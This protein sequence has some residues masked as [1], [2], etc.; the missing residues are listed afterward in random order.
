LIV[1]IQRK[2]HVQRMTYEDFEER[3]RDGEV[4]PE[5]LIRFE[6]VT[7]DEFRPVGELELYHALAD[8]QRLA[9]RASLSRSGMPIVTAML[10]GFQLR[11]YLLSWLGGREEWLERTFTNWSPAIIEQGQV[12]RLISY[13]LLQTSFTHLL[14]NLYFLA[15]TAYHLE[16]AM[17]RANLLL[18]Y[19]GSVFTGGL[20]S[21]VMA[22]DRPSLGASCGVF[23][24]LAAVV[25]LG[26]KH[27][28]NL[29]RQ[30][31]KYFGWALAPYLGFSILSGLSA[32]NVDNWGHLGGLV[33]GVVLMTVLDPELIPEQRAANART[34]QITLALLLAITLGL[35]TAGTRLVPLSRYS[36]EHGW[37]VR[38]P[39]PWQEG[40]TFTGDR[41]WF[42]PTLLA[43]VSIATTVHPRP[44]TAETA[45]ENLEKRIASGGKNPKRVAWE[46][47]TIQ[48]WD[49]IRMVLRFD[50]SGEP[51]EVT[52][53][54]LVRGVYEHRILFQAL[55]SAARNYDPLIERI[56][57]SVVM[58]DSRSLVAARRRAQYHPRSWEPALE[59]GDA[60]YQAGAPTEAQRYYERALQID[61]TDPRP[62]VGLLRVYA[63]YDIPG[64]LSLA[65]AALIDHSS[66]LK[67]VEAAADVIAQ[68]G[69]RAEAIEALDAAWAASPDN[70]VLRRIRL[71]WG[72]PISAE[73]SPEEPA[74]ED[75]GLF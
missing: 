75:T 65:R 74:P 9:F 8:P 28:E 69:E 16:R 27:W 64:A 61:P 29:P 32:D 30:S 31:R 11:V 55:A 1:E 51:Q 47:V 17:G 35:T 15:Y 10:V 34:R 48:D 7:G 22:P 33:G 36:D 73:P 23:G 44:I 37:N 59:L 70:A 60:L 50:L 53:L 20:L 18:L 49:A 41:G 14:F 19:F 46:A 39:E 66:S 26:W 62:L 54:V 38:R 68:E 6:V 45:A 57:D 58:A 5:T 25:I 24:L 43:N 52:A 2:S 21:M 42:S 4:S 12:Y 67:V 71:Q 13:G 63:D 56:V 40:W 3:I 72:L